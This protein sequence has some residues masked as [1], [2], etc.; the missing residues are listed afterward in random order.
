MPMTTFINI[1][2]NKKPSTTESIGRNIEYDYFDV[3]NEKS[4]IFAPTGEMAE[5]SKAH[6][7]KVCNR[8]KRFMGSNPILSAGF[9]R[10]SFF[11]HCF[12]NYRETMSAKYHLGVWTI[13]GLF[14]VLVYIGL[15]FYMIFFPNFNEAFNIPPEYGSLKVFFGIFLIAYGI[16]RFVRI[17]PKLKKNQNNEEE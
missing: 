16:I 5:W 15:G 3:G 2:K 7:W 1:L 6:A 17:L 10:S 8:Q 13:F 12:F 11:N 14:M 9:Y 4:N